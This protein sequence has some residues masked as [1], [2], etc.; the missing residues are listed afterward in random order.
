MQTGAT[1][2]QRG[3]VGWA[4]EPNQAGFRKVVVVVVVVQVVAI[5]RQGPRQME[6]RRTTHTQR[7]SCKK[8]TKRTKK[9]CRIQKG[10]QGWA[11][12][13]L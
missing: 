4:I 13:E 12:Y 8:K 3:T 9:R 1:Q 10:G 5:L 11:R 2:G 7:R 6:T